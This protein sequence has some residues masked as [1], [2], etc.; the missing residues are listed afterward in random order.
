VVVA[1]RTQ[2]IDMKKTLVMAAEFVGLLAM[3]ALLYVA[4]LFG[5]ALTAPVPV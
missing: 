1:E 2:E 3:F 5:H 4:M